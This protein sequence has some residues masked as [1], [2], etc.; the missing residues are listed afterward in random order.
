[1]FI[2]GSLI[3][4]KALHRVRP[5]IATRSLMI[6]LPLAMILGTLVGNTV[7]DAIN[8]L[9]IA[10]IALIML[11]TDAALGQAVVKSEFVPDR[12]HRSISVES[13]LNDGI[14]QPP[15]RV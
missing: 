10:L 1:M 7:I 12:I 2:D 11:P 13:G 9:G 6:R 8:L 3:D 15:V 4:L 5:R 14:A